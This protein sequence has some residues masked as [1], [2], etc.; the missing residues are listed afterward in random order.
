MRLDNGRHD[1]YGFLI[2]CHAH[3]VAALEQAE[4]AFELYANSHESHLSDQQKEVTDSLH[5]G[6]QKS[7]LYINNPDL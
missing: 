1:A 2:A 5:R 4:K 6:I 3:A 7:S